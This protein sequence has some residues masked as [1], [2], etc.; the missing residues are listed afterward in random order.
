MQ[1]FLIAVVF[2]VAAFLPGLAGAENAQ[3]QKMKTC[4]AEASSKQLKGEA[5]KTFMAQCLHAGSDAS[6][7]NAKGSAL[8]ELSAQQKKMKECSGEAKQ[9]NLHGTERENFLKTCLSAAH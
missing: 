1:R 2:V 4:N 3:Q 8:P 7:D 6:A 9:K 5:R